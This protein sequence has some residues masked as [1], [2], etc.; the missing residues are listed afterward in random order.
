M[1][2]FIVGLIVGALL[3]F[4][5]QAFGAITSLVGKK[6]SSELVVDV[7]GKE[8]GR[9]IIISNKA[10]LPV[11]EVAIAFDADIGIKEGGVSLTTDVS[12]SSPSRD[13][14]AEESQLKVELESLRTTKEKLE[15]DIAAV[16]VSIKYFEETRIPQREDQLARAINDSQRESFQK[17]IQDFKNIVLEKKASLPILEAELTTVIAK[18]AELEEQS[19]EQ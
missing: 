15:K 7:N 11:R 19:T 3:M 13:V 5:G 18:I 9:G 10:Y 17:D 16:P 4:S 8:I 2:K 1:R 14:V 6:V 12:E